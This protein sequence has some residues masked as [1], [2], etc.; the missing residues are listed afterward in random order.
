MMT[1]PTEWKNKTCSKPTTSKELQ[2]LNDKLSECNLHGAV[3]LPVWRHQWLHLLRSG[4][5]ES[6]ELAPA[7]GSVQLSHEILKLRH[8]LDLDLCELLPMFVQFL[9]TRKLCK[10][11]AS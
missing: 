10:L 7:S 2:P 5:F 11:L 1:F 8:A 4:V 9:D 3:A 6:E